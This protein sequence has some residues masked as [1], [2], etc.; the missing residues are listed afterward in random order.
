MTTQGDLWAIVLAGGRGQRLEAFLR[1]QGHLH[2]IKQFCNI[3]GRRTM[4]E[5][6]WARVEMLMAHERVLTVIGATHLAEFPEQ[7]DARWPGTVLGQPVNRET[8]P[9]ILLPLAQ[10]LRADPFA[11][12]GIF[13]SDHFVLEER[14]LMAQAWAASNVV[15]DGVRDVVILGATP[16]RADPEYGWI[17][18]RHGREIAPGVLAVERFREKPTL[19]TAARLYRG[20]HLWS[21][22]IVVARAAA[23]WELICEA[24]PQLRRPFEKIREALGTADEADVL[25]REYVAIPEVSLS[26]GVLEQFPSRLGVM[27][28]DGIYWSDWGREERIQETLQ[29]LDWLFHRRQRSTTSE[30]RLASM[31]SSLPP[32][33]SVGAR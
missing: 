26:Q 29:R 15:R 30:G 31:T 13:P 24:Q 2:P 16:T 11:V 19:E 27:A 32:P 10:V 33:S 22:M 3:V 4:L 6:T 25:Q 17:E 12:V 20:G 18:V 1:R 7:L 28:L 23:L 5:H 8:A 21:T 9:G 14:R